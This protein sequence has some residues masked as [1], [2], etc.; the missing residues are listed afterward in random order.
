MT[1]S[2]PRYRYP[3]L[4][5]GIGAGDALGVAIGG[6]FDKTALGVAIGLALGVVL[7]LS[8]RVRCSADSSVDGAG[9]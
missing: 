7:G 6:L 5:A 8:R 1:D 9:H 3:W 4:P 2:T